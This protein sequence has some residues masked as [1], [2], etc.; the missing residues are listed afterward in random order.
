MVGCQLQ[1][2]VTM[3]VVAVVAANNVK[4]LHS[5]GLNSPVL[6]HGILCM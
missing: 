3:V 4:P 1:M 5:S 6:M 2:D